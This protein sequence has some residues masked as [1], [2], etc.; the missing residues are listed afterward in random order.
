[1]SMTTSASR[2][3]D[4]PALADELDAD[5]S[6]GYVSD[7]LHFRLCRFLRSLPSGSSQSATDGALP[8]ATTVLRDL[9]VTRFLAWKLPSTFSPDCGISFDGRGKDARGGDKG[10]PV[11]TNLLTAEEAR[12]MFEYCLAAPQSARNEHE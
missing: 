1:M 8:E 7:D 12:A 11:G 5:W 10:W 2:A 6:R 3:K 9:C 4:G